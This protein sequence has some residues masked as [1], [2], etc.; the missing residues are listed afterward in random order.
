[1]WD[2][3]WTR[4]YWYRSLGTFTKLRKVTL[5]FVMSVHMFAWNNSAATGHIVM[6]FGIKSIFQKSVKNIEVSLHY[7]K[8]NRYVTLKT[9]MHF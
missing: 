2:P 3:W 4:W 9:N 7:D 6:K 8:N 1:V 5:S